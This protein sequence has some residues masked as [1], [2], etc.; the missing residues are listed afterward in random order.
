MHEPRLPERPAVGD[1]E[2]ARFGIAGTHAE[3]TAP[4]V[5]QRAPRAQER[6][7]RARR[8]GSGERDAGA[9]G[10]E[11]PPRSGEYPV[12][13]RSRVAVFE[14]DAGIGSVE[15]TSCADERPFLFGVGRLRR[16]RIRGGGC[17]GRYDRSRGGRR[18][19]RGLFAVGIHG[20]RGGRDGGKR[21]LA[22]GGRR[23]RGGRRAVREKRRGGEGGREKVRR[24][25]RAGGEGPVETDRR[26]GA[27]RRSSGRC[28]EG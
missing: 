17:D 26:E 5:A 6:R 27:A 20:S 21:R 24:A 8:R 28:R 4:R 22:C 15:L 25:G 14:L 2:L 10:A 23:R 3:E 12:Q 19:G 11:P 18:G 1:Q 9:D 7:A 13:A 16:R